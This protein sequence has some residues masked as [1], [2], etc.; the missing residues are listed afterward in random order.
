MNKVNYI[1]RKKVASL[2]G[3]GIILTSLTIP[4]FNDTKFK[5]DSAEVNIVDIV[6]N[7]STKSI[8][9][10]VGS[11]V[12]NSVND[13]LCEVINLYPSNWL[14]A[15]NLNIEDRLEYERMTGTDRVCFYVKDNY[16]REP[17][18]GLRY[19]VVDSNSNIIDDFTTD[20]D[21]HIINRLVVG[22]TYTIRQMNVKEDYERAIYT[23][24]M[25]TFNH[26]VD[27]YNDYYYGQNLCLYLSK[28]SD[29]KRLQEMEANKFYHGSFSVSAVDAMDN[30][31][32]PGVSFE[33]Y[34]SNN[35][36]KDSWISDDFYH[37]VTNLAD[38]MYKIKIAKIVSGY[39]FDFN[40]DIINPYA[41]LEYIF[42][43]DVQIRDGK[44]VDADD[45]TS[46]NYRGDLPVYFY[47]SY[48]YSLSYNNP[49][50]RILTNN[51]I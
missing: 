26:E 32:I 37:E 3:C 20:G 38:G 25:T 24:T 45:K 1:N 14:V 15:R 9:N 36:L 22:E 11:N 12:S 28:S 10:N 17:I 42:E 19:V 18:S 6:D 49:K 50:K 47:R 27:D 48:E 21:Y 40:V 43:Y 8:N 2:I 46:E 44:L 4:T 34:D 51:N 29:K 16:T 33:V 23:F 13:E 35:N 30:T 5:Q 31:Y 41:D 7:E 39:D